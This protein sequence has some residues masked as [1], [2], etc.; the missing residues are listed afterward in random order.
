MKKMIQL[1][2]TLTA[3]AAL[4]GTSIAAMYEKTKGT[5]EKQKMEYLNNSLKSLF[6]EGATIT[7]DT[8]A[9]QDGKHVTFWIAQSDN[10]EHIGYALKSEKY[11]YSSIVRSITAIDSNGDIL[12]FSV[13][14][15][16]ET[17][18]LGSRTMESV[19]DATFW[20]GLFKKTEKRKPWF[21]DQFK[22]LS[23][24]TPISIGSGAEWHSLTTENQQVLNANNE[25]SAITGATITTKAVTES[26]TGLSVLLNEINSHFAIEE[27]SDDNQ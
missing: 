9:L 19:S 17:P 6:P 20:T 11:G 22:G 10:N 2:V 7:E 15:Q 26:L 16:E 14:S 12:G 13:L 27:I 21:Q 25:V 18:G 5:I 3:I 4:A 24:L 8:L 1:T 23:V